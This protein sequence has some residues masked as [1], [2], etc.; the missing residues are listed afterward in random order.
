MSRKRADTKVAKRE[1][2]VESLEGDSQSGSRLSSVT[3]AIRL[4]KQFSA[5]D[6]ELG[7]STLARSL[8]V[9]K[10]TAHRLASTLLAE[11]LLEQDP[12]TERY[13]LGLGV[14]TLGALVRQRLSVSVE[15]KGL[16]TELRDDIKENVAL[17]VLS[18][19]QVTFVYDLESPQPVRV[20]SRFG[21]S[22][23]AL[24]CAEGIAMLAAQS[25]E[26]LEA[27]LRGFG[28]PVPMD[29]HQA[30]MEEIKH[31]RRHGFVVES[32]NAA[33]GATYIAAPIRDAAGT[34]I[35][36]VGVA[37]PSQRIT[38]RR[39]KTLA[40]KV[41]DTADAVSRRLGFLAPSSHSA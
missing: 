26:M 40:P 15:A 18:G 36:A 35:A 25:N 37:A 6:V 3:A 38:T 10:S 20:S 28:Q 41:I 7:I 27:A 1:D 17:A 23:P 14:F 11:G 8:D 9:S 24:G 16:I 22:K 34:V 32:D 39:L 12:V 5:Q 31:A 21:F 2:A 19:S 29:R 13:K 4:L 33:A 30:L